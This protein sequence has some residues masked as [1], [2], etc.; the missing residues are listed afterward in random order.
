MKKIL[1]IV[2]TGFEDTELVTTNN[3]LLR[4]GYETTLASIEDLSEVKA[5]RFTKV[6]TV[7]FS[8]LNLEEY[9]AIVIP[10]GKGH[11]LMLN[12]VMIKIALNHFISEEKLV[13]A[14]CA[15]P[16]VLYDLGILEGKTYTSFPN[17]AVS[18][19]NTGNEVEIDG[20]IIT[21]RDYLATDKFAFKISEYLK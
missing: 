17:H 14:I 21:G 9:D 13:A 4:E 8:E 12:N 6:D 16:Q 20:N 2:S 15:A 5:Q 3:I 11:K 18:D 7:K 19:S 10:G 1:I